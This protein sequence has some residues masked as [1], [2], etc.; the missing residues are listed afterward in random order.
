MPAAAASVSGGS[1]ILTTITTGPTGSMNHGNTGRCRMAALCD[2]REV[3]AGRVP[4]PIADTH[5]VLA[6]PETADVARPQL[7]A[8]EVEELER[9]GR[10]IGKTQRKRCARGR[11]PPQR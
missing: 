1:A 10:R 11:A 2:P 7:P 8:R 3:D 4:R 9:S 5:F 6:R